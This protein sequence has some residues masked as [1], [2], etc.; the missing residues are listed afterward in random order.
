[1]TP[2]VIGFLLF[3][4]QHYAVDMGLIRKIIKRFFWEYH[5]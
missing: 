4:F 1:M 5:F 3:L 2:F